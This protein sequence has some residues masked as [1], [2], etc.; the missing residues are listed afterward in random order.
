MST[1]YQEPLTTFVIPSGSNVSQLVSGSDFTQF[2]SATYYVSSSFTGIGYLLARPTP[3]SDWF[4]STEDTFSAGY[5]YHEP[6]I[7]ASD[8]MFSSSLAQSTSSGVQVVGAY[9]VDVRGFVPE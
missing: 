2:G 9:Q 1:G 7:A 3:N 6:T 8:F 4:I 5:A